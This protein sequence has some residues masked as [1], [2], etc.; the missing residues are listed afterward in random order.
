MA[1]QLAGHDAL[2]RDAIENH[3]G[4]IF[5]TA[6]DGFAA[7]FVT[8]ESAAAT[9]IEIQRELSASRSPLRVRIGLNTGET[10]ERDGNYFGPAVNRA[11]RLR[12]IAQG[13]QV[14][15]SELT[16]RLLTEGI[17][18][19]P[20]VDLGE[21]RLK[22][23]QRPEHVFQVGTD[24]FAP[25]RP[26]ELQ[27]HNLPVQLTSFVGRHE[28]VETIVRLVRTNRFVVLTGVGGV[29]KTRLAQEAA[30]RLV[31]DA[32]DG[33]FFVD[34]AP[35]S[36]PSLVASTVASAIGLA[37]AEAGGITDEGLMAWLAARRSLVLLDNCEHLLDACAELAT[38]ILA[39]GGSG[40][41]LATS[42]EAFGLAGEHDWQVPSLPERSGVDLFEV[43]ARAVRSNFV[44]D[45]HN[46]G[47][48]EEICR[49]LDGIPLAL[50]LAAARVA[51]L[52]PQQIADRLNDR[53]RLL[54]GGRQR[55]QRQQ[56]LHAALEWSH[57]L[58]EPVERTLFR[59]LAVFNGSFALTSAEAA[60]S[61][62]QLAIDAVV[63]VLGSLVGKSIVVARAD[64]RYRLLE[65]VRLFAEERLVDADEAERFRDRHRDWFVEWVESFPA[66]DSL[67]SLEAADAMEAD[68]DNV[69][70]A[71]NWSL[72][73]QRSD[74]AGRL[75]VATNPMW[76]FHLHH[77]EAM[78]WLGQVTA[79]AEGLEPDLRVRCGAWATSA[80]M[81]LMTDDAVALARETTSTATA[82]ASGPA[83]LTW[84][85]LVTMTGMVAE[86]RGDAHDAAVEHALRQALTV[87]PTW[88]AWRYMA[89][90]ACANGLVTIGRYKEAVDIAEQCRDFKGISEDVMLGNFGGPAHG[91][92]IVG[93]HLLGNN[94]RSLEEAERGLRVETPGTRWAG[95]EGVAFA[96]AGDF[97]S[98]RVRALQS[99]DWERIIP[100]SEAE[101]FIALGVIEALADE[102]ERSSV[103]FAAG[104]AL[105]RG[106]GGGFRSPMSYALYK[107]YLPR[108]RANLDAETARRARDHGR[109]MT[110][111]AALQFA[112]GASS[113]PA[114]SSRPEPAGP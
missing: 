1:E 53:F 74:L 80:A 76:R 41:L 25:L 81:A 21:Q 87:H 93:W 47:V 61:D 58:L 46:V 40:R 33:V 24:S 20:L 78:Q 101:T 99:L 86:A 60:C 67:F 111:E 89:L 96:A 73:Q 59:R 5:S 56:T 38:R 105:G 108:V 72:L 104:R 94:N 113:A 63:E 14:L 88:D 36:D 69:A 22:D 2:M 92:L 32:P 114:R 48:V 107:H 79:D 65:T 106:R 54:T 82:T 7:A 8:A 68:H 18:S 112:Q 27:R 50:E 85:N 30:A 103:L 57:D 34:L 77:D 102:H 3:G 109:A 37:S 55:V 13:G 97:R 15:C 83:A 43:R 90:S 44:I 26:L 52:T 95:F 62:G 84:G 39:R 75:V 100:L 19:P 10:E 4:H 9:A 70:A 42:R 110:L 51:Y 35:V 12:D 23:L 64:G 49:R 28:A 31:D 6:G 71:V 17:A 66:T 11:G 29:G 16:A 45:D 91:V 98:A